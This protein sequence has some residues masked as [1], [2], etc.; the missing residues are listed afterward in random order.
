MLL[1]IQ[2]I[3][4][5]VKAQTADKLI[6]DRY[7]LMDHENHWLMDLWLLKALLFLQRT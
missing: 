4:I 5:M 6:L 2:L 1:V 3:H 7:G